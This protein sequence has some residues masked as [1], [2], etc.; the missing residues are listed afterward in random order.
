MT[1]LP[2][3]LVYSRTAVPQ[4]LL[5]VFIGIIYIRTRVGQEYFTRCILVHTWY[6]QGM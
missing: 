1:R 2:A 5:L 6:L 3:H 4:Y